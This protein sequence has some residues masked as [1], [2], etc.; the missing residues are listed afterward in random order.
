MGWLLPRDSVCGVLEG[1]VLKYNGGLVYSLQAEERPDKVNGSLLP[2]LSEACFW[3]GGVPPA[4]WASRVSESR[5]FGGG[6]PYNLDAC[7]RLG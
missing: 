3:S 4:L 5:R 1:K 2:H 6:W 7:G